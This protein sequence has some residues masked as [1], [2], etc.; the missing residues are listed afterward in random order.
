MRLKDK[1]I[2]SSQQMQ[3]RPFSKFDTPHDKCPGEVR[4]ISN[5]SQHN[6]NSLEKAYKYHQLK[7]IKKTIL[8]NKTV[9][10]IGLQYRS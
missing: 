9:L 7:W 10:T 3:E 1:I 6:K 2:K 4:E 5:I 8:I